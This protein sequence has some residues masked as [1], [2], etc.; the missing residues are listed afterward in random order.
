[1]HTRS[2]SHFTYCV[3]SCLQHLR[4][5]RAWDQP[6]VVAAVLAA[7]QDHAATCGEGRTYDLVM[8]LRHLCQLSPHPPAGEVLPHGRQLLLRARVCCVSHTVADAAGT[9]RA[10]APCACAACC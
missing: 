10:T 1:M 2:L 4:Q 6:G 9:A 8:L 3:T 5:Q 7:L